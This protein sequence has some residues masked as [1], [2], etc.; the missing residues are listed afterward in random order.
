MVKLNKEIH[1]TIG[2]LIMELLSP[3]LDI[4]FKKMFSDPGNQPLLTDFLSCVLDVQPEQIQKIVIENSEI[5][6]ANIGDKVIRLDLML[7]MD[8][9][10]I[11]IEM[12]CISDK[13]YK[14]RVLYYWAKLYTRDIKVGDKYSDLEQTISINICDFNMFECE[15]YHSTFGIYEKERN[16]QLTDKFRIDFL[17]LPKARKYKSKQLRRLEKWMRFFNIKSE[18]DADM[19]AKIDKTMAQ[20]V[21]ELREMSQD[22]KTR[23]FAEA[24]E[25]YLR[26]EASALNSA[27]DEGIKE[28]RK[29]GIKEGRKEGRKEGIKEGRKEGIDI[30][31]EKMRL[32]GMSEE[33]IKIILSL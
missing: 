24:R 1:C 6:P 32:F 12:Q 18:E 4:I 20:A 30:A 9:K 19:V 28:G 16:E 29:E 23:A 2:G 27:R 21:M 14:D 5:M 22:E 31:M 11:D 15:E 7:S 17:E 3:K 8:G 10:K 26:D 25:A 33:E 13:A